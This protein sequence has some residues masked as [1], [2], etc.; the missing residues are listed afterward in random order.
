MSCFDRAQGAEFCVWF[1]LKY[2]NFPVLMQIHCPNKP[3]SAR[4]PAQHSDFMVFVFF[5]DMMKYFLYFCMTQVI[6]L[7]PLPR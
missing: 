3:R 5:N 7:S 6:V 4:I 1:A 2:E